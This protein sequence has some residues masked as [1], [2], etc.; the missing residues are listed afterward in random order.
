[1]ALLDQQGF[2]N[3]F[4][5]FKGEPQQDEAVE[6]LRQALPSSLLE[7]DAKW[8]QK[9]RQTPPAPVYKDSAIPPEAIEIICEF[10]GFRAEPYNDGMNVPTIGYGS[11]FYEDGRKV[12]YKDPAITEARGRSMMENIAEKD[13]WDVIKHT[14]PFWSEMSDGQKSALLDFSYNLGAHFYG[15]SGFSTISG[16]LREKRWSDVPGALMLYVNPGTAVEAGL[17]RRRKAEGELWVS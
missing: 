10:E 6:M 8:V 9:Y 3:F 2:R 1:M 12:T 15:G 5:Y 16:C 7:E 17:K 11:T 14:I 4:Q 13:F